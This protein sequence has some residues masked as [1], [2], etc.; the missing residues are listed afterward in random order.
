M[1]KKMRAGMMPPAG[2]PRPSFETMQ[3]FASSLETTLDGHAKPNL[4]VPKLHRLNRTEYAN[5]VRDLLGLQ[6]DSTQF[7]PSDD[8]SRGFDNQAGTL[9]LSPALL[10]AYLSAAARISRL[11]VGEAAPPTQ[12]TYRVAADTTQNY[13]VENLPF[14]TRGGLV[15]DHTF[16]S[17]GKYTVKVFSVNLGNMGNFRPFGEIRGE[18]LLVYVDDVRVAQVDWDKALGVGRRFDEEGSGELHTID[19]TVPVAAGAHRIGVTFLATNY[20]PG[21]DVNHA[22][23]R[24]TIE[25]GGLPGYTFYP[26]IGSVRIDGPYEAATA[27]ASQSRARICTCQ[28]KQASEEQACARQ[29]ASRSSHDAPIADLARPSDVDTLMSFYRHRPQE[30]DVRQRRRRHRPACSRRSEIRLSR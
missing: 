18:Q 30:R 7:L 23:D 21:L 3:S 1:L 22:F 27:T 13:H 26:H 25:T 28:P 14:G 19:V 10:E 12:V 11:A 4:H 2:K 20:A 5:A 15:V 29:I 6:L 16:P 8:V 17:N 9:S 24:S